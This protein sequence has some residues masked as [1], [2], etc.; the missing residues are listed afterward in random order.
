MARVWSIALIGALLAPSAV[1]AAAYDAD[2][3]HSSVEFSVRHLVG[4]VKGRFAQ[5]AAVIEYDA[6]RPEDSRV[7]ASVQVASIIT[8]NERRDAHLRGPD[9]FDADRFPEMTFASTS[10]RRTEDGLQ[11]EGMLTIHGVTKQVSIPVE[12]LGEGANPNGKS[13]IGFAGEFTVDRSDF[14]IV[15]NTILDQGGTLV[16]EK[17]KVMLAIEAVVRD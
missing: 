2:P 7:T 15:W 9:F 1:A 6:A 16:G 13:V 4:K 10:V 11:L 8:D 14:G 12:I 3:T 5:F 17:V